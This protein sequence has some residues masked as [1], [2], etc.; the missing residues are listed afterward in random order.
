[1]GRLNVMRNQR[2]PTATIK[3]DFGKNYAN[4]PLLCDC[5]F[6][7]R[8]LPSPPPTPISVIL[9]ADFCLEIYIYVI[10]SALFGLTRE[11][12]FITLTLFQFILPPSNEKTLERQD[13]PFSRQ[14]PMVLREWQMPFCSGGCNLPQSR[15]CSSHSLLS[16]P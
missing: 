1:M 7:S 6:L 16:S 9:P 2:Q 11:N 14:V 8:R 4:K 3:H 13:S 5:R 10:Y 12:N 15:N